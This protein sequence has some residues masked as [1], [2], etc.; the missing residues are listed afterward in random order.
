MKFE[1]TFGETVKKLREEKQLPL[2]EVA[3]ALKIDTSMLGKI[4]K[5][6]RKPT[7]HLIEKFAKYF[8]VSDKDLMIAFI[9]DTVAYQIM[10]E[11]DFASE[12]LKVA[13]KKVKYL[14]NKKSNQ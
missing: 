9:S 8:N 7:K 14:K 4:E 11:E 3:E 13:E 2:R 12:V 10:N 1:K 6:N 5:N